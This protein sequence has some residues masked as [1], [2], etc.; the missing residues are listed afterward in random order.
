MGHAPGGFGKM[1]FVDI[2]ERGGIRPHVVAA[3]A[4]HADVCDDDPVV[5]PPVFRCAR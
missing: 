3:H 5:G 2:A 1:V 4:A